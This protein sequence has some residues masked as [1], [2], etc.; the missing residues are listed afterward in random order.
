MRRLGREREVRAIQQA[1]APIA[2]QRNRRDDAHLRAILA[3][4]LPPDANCI[5]VGANVGNILDEFVRLAPRGRHIAYEPLPD[6]A[7]QLRRRFP[8][9]DVRCAALSD[10]GGEATFHRD[11]AHHTRSGLRPLGSQTE[12]LQVRVE[13]LDDSLPEDFVP[14][15][16][17]IDVEGAELAVVRGGL[18]TLTRHR[19][20]VVFEHGRGGLAYGTTHGM[21]H[22][23]LCGEAGLRIFDMDGD[24]PFDRPAF[25]RVASPPGHLWN[26]IARP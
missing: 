13:T 12:P 8:S 17:K 14:D 7:A 5:D 26:F 3:A 15:V 18:K 25:E 6:I 4:T 19:P 2:V 9:V 11:V 23:L 21:I 10:R 1:L 22:D 20:L 16:I 24:G